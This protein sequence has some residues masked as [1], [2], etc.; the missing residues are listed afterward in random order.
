MVKFRCLCDGQCCKRYWIPVTHLD[1]LRL[2]I[3]GNIKVD[4]N[5]VELK[6]SEQ[7][8]LDIY[9]PIKI[10]NKEYYLGL[11]L[12]E[13]GSCIFLRS[14]GKCAVHEFKPLVCRFYP[15]VYWFKENGEIDIDLN[16]KAIG[17]C[18]GLILDGEPIDRSI[19]ESLKRIARIRREELKLWSDIINEWN[20]YY[21]N[22]SR[23]L[24]LFLKFA[25]EK[26]EIH[27]KELI[28]RGLWIK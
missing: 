4:E 14:D 12:K 3:Y 11:A 24:K 19:V 6:D 27:R 18:L 15:F 8:E 26:A 17:E 2:Q 9:P 28:K 13:D 1:L 7:Y 22:E 21:G 23:N 16:E 5:I 10:N 20:K 25:F